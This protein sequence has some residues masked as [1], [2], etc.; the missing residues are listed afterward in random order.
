M[1]FDLILRNITK[2][3]SLNSREKDYFCSL[4]EPKSIRRKEYLLHEGE[5]CRYASF[6]TRGCLYGYTVDDNG[7]EHVISFAP[8]DWWISD[9]YSAISQKPAR[10]NIQAQQDSD[11]QMLSRKNQ[12]LLYTKVPKFERFFRIIIENSLVANQQ[13]LIDN[14]SLTAEE[15][16]KNFC[17]RYPTLTATL[18]QKHIASYIGVTPE[19]F[20]KMRSRLNSKSR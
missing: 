15:R 17:R 8:V 7:D 20:S 16:F 9:L 3:I 11:V 4:L 12:E 13:R 18:P 14:L 5:V 19:F 10:M 1:N 6:V 2:H